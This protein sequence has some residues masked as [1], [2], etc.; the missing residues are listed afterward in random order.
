MLLHGDGTNG[1]QNNT[2]LDSS[3]NAFTITRNGDTTQGTFSPFSHA[4]GWWSNY[5]NNSGYLSLGSN[6]A[7]QPGSGDFTVEAWFNASALGTGTGGYNAIVSYGGSS[8]NLRI[9]IQ[10]TTPNVTI[11]DGASLFTNVASSS[12]KVG[13]WNHIAVVRSGSTI[14]T[15]LNGTSIGTA[16]VATNFTGTLNVGSESGSYLWT[17]YISNVRVVKGTAVYT[18]AFTPPTTPLTAIANTGALTCQS[19]R[20]KDNS[21]NN[22]AVT[23]NSTPSV[24]VFSPFNPTTAYLAAT[25]GGS[26]YFDGSGDYLGVPNDAAFNLGTSDATIEAWVYYTSQPGSTGQSILSCMTGSDGYEF[27]SYPYGAGGIAIGMQSFAGGYQQIYATN[28]YIPVNTWAHIA[29]TRASGTNRLFVNGNLCTTTGTLTNT[30]NTGGTAIQIARSVY[31]GGNTLYGYLSGV[32]VLKGTAQYTS[33]FT[34]PTAP[35]TAITNTSLLLNFTNGGI[36]DNAAMNDLITVG[37]AQVSTAQKKFGTGSMYFDGSGDYLQMPAT[38]NVAFSTGDFTIEFWAYS[39]DVS[40]STQRSHLQTSTT[41]GGFS[42]SYNTGITFFQ[43]ATAALGQL[44]GGLA[45]ALGT[46]G[47]YSVVGGSSV[48]TANTWQHIA[49]TRSGNSV[50]LFADGVQVGS[51]LTYTSSID[52]TNMVIGGAYQTTYFLYLGYIDDLRI[53]KGYARYTANFTPPTEAFPNL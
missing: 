22:F 10:G 11:W 20:F 17:G 44:N 31:S 26:G 49:L 36:F 4:D 16:T 41:A 13:E 53:T 5:F 50:R 8:G 35:P 23:V 27:Y 6:A 1:A 7:L 48:L 30:L 42:T 21:A 14:T 52:A 24:Q 40:G 9:F 15:Y 33:A 32:R 38:Q 45:V 43:G 25:N 39:G 19:N 28:N 34:P 18:G 47:S 37:G 51:T 46:G 29:F 2:F 12:I 3:T